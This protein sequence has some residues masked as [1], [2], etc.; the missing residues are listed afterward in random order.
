MTAAV[1]SLVVDASVAAKW[2]LQDE[3]EATEALALLARYAAGKLRLFAPEHIRYEVPSTIIAA[4]LV[5][6]PRLSPA[7]AERSIATFLSLGIQ[8]VNTDALIRAGFPLV[9]RY[10]IA[11]YDAVYLALAQELG[12]SL[13]TADRK[14]YRRVGELPEVIWLGDYPLP[15]AGA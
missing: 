12:V 7:N 11:F 8:T 14:L 6:P 13:I 1:E 9:R 15:A 10:R 4:T 3:D 2:H 5:T